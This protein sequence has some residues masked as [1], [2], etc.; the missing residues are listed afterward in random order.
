MKK[1]SQISKTK[2]SNQEEVKKD[3]NYLDYSDEVNVDILKQDKPRKAKRSKQSNIQDTKSMSSMSTKSVKAPRESKLKEEVVSESR[4]VKKIGKIAKF[5]KG[6][7]ASNAYNYLED[8][9][10]SKNKIWY[11]LIEKQGNELQMVKYSTKQGVN[12][13]NF[14]NELKG[15]YITKYGTESTK[16]LLEQI[17]VAGDKQGNFS[18][19]KNIPNIDVDGVKL[20]RKLTEDLTILLNGK[21]K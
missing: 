18:M 17:H 8:V 10:I 12:L 14:I 11:M 15:Y 9:K 19:I 5:P 2:V 21:C 6:T 16:S 13:T 7:K 3:D 1:F 20:I 4:K